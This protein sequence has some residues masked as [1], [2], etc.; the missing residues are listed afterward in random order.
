M[1]PFRFI[2]VHDARLVAVGTL[3]EAYRSIDAAYGVVL[4]SG[5]VSA[6]LRPEDLPADAPAH[7][8]LTGYLP[9]VHSFEPVQVSIVDA[10]EV[11]QVAFEPTVALIVRDRVPFVVAAGA[12]L[13]TT[14]DYRALFASADFAA[15][16][17]DF[18]LPGPPPPI[19]PRERRCRC[20]QGHVVIVPAGQE[21]TACPFDGLPLR[22]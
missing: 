2:A 11:W 10:A 16:A 19:E 6:V 17:P 3:R 22:C 20:P 12:P 13:R 1:T 21:V 9:V 7:E 14:A 8:P 4:D 5:T 15:S 18:W